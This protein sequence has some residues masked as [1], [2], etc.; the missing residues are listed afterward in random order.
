[1][2]LGQ[3]AVSFVL[4]IA[5]GVAPAA[6][7]WCAGSCE[8]MRDALHAHSSSS[9]DPVCHRPVPART[10][11][12]QIPGPCGHSHDGS[13]T[14]TAADPAPQFS[15]PSPISAVQT[16]PVTDAIVLFASSRV[17][18]HTGPPLDSH[19]PARILALRI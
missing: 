3:M 18:P 19:S 2:R 10:H 11:V 7:D 1:M 15:A 4:A 13:P 8:A 12:D 9:S 14:L 16:A 5:L 17:A 6:A